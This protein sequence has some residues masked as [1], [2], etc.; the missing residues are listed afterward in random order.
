MLYGKPTKHIRHA[1]EDTITIGPQRMQTHI[2]WH[3]DVTNAT[4]RVDGADLKDDKLLPLGSRINK[5]KLEILVTPE[6]IEPQQLYMGRI[7]FSFNDIFAPHV[8]G[9][10]IGQTAYQTSVGNLNATGYFHMFPSTLPGDKR[11]DVTTGDIDIG[12]IQDVKL[13]DHFKHF[14]SLKKITV[15]DQRP[16][17]GERWQ[18]IPSKVKRANDYTFYGL[19]LFNDAPRGGTPAD[20]QL[21]INLKSY[22][23]EMAV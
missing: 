7:K 8:M 11:V 6:T 3:T 13:D 18:R 1:D 19:W 15:F 9:K 14:C 23:E 16:L 4:A 12:G 2:F 20:T 21:T 5:H 10:T 22:W 17:M